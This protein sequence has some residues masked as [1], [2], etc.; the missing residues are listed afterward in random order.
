VPNAQVVPSLG[1]N[2]AAG[3]AATVTVPIVP[4]QTMFEDRLT[5]LDVRFTKILKVGRGR[6]QGM[7]DIYNIFNA[8]TVLV[9]R[10]TYGPAW[11]NAGQVLGARLFKFGA[12][13]DF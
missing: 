7:F 5:Q 11:L 13:L 2:L 8:N 9:S 3:A 10:N 6:L 12:Q 1:R 4:P